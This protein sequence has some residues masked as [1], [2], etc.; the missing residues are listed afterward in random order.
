[1][2][3]HWE[4]NANVDVKLLL[5]HPRTSSWWRPCQAV[6]SPDL[7]LWSHHNYYNYHRALPVE[8]EK[9]VIWGELAKMMSHTDG[10]PLVKVIILTQ[11]MI[12]PKPNKL[13]KFYHGANDWSSWEDSRKSL[14]EK[15]NSHINII[16][17]LYFSFSVFI[18]STGLWHKCK[19]HKLC[20]S[21]LSPP[22]L[23][24]KGWEKSLHHHYGSLSQTII[25]IISILAVDWQINV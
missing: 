6:T 12:F 17:A 19:L 15:E 18:C 9:Y 20:T 10:L 24:L 14:E 22:S 21:S 3:W 2:V 1:M 13:L 25:N 4:S 7:L 5:A 23:Y 8:H 11:T 16:P